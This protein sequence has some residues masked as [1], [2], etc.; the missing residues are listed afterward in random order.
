MGGTESKSEKTENLG[1]VINEV[2]AEHKYDNS[3]NEKILT[4]VFICT[5]LLVVR[6]LYKVYKIYHTNMKKKYSLTNV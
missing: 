6:F 3:T 2:E 1:T 4:L 5:L